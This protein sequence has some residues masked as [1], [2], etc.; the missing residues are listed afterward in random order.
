MKWVNLDLTV[1]LPNGIKNGPI[2]APS[3]ENAVHEVIASMEN[4]NPNPEPN[5]TGKQ[6][7]ISFRFIIYIHVWSSVSYYLLLVNAESSTSLV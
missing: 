7:P 5:T 3:Q 4:T 1:N 6:S 2:N